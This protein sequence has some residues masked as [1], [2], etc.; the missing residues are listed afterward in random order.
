MTETQSAKPRALGFAVVE[1]EVLHLGDIGAPCS[2]SY[3]W[4]CGVGGTV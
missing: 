1:S 3:V 4:H 2:K